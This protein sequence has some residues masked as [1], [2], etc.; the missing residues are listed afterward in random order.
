M[1]KH[2]FYLRSTI[3]TFLFIVIITG[4]VFATCRSTTFNPINDI[5]WECIYPV[6]IGGMEVIGTDLDSPPDTVG[7]QVCACGEGATAIVGVSSSFWEPARII[8]TVKDP[9]CFN[10]IG[11]NLSQNDDG[12]LAGT[13][14]SDT[15]KEYT[16][17]Q[18]HYY[19]LNV[20]SFLDLFMDMPCLEYQGF[21]LAY[22]TE[23]DPLWNDDLLAFILN[24]E[25]ILFGNPV[26]Q[27]ACMADAA[28]STLGYPLDVL[29]WCMG[30][31]GS[32]YPLAGHKTDNFYVQDN[33]AIAA[34]LVYKLTRQ[35][36]LWDTASNVCGPIMF[37]IWQKSHFRMH[38]MKPVKD[39]TCHPI[40][41]SGM[42]WAEMKNP[43]LNTEGDAADNFDWVL[44]RKVLCCV[45]FS[46]T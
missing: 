44:F 22:L 1:I 35:L 27:L 5:C 2:C 13:L 46:A 34:K 9:Y 29:F 3:Y 18:A 4:N 36:M 45:G 11:A 14:A 8:E 26:M 41:R 30:S 16:A 15:G 7:S 31:W 42:I 6:S 40:G 32:S 43:T 20:W 37:P 25:A 17:T 39:W 23:I 33:A 38:V 10:L 12:F 24:P 21:D 28:A 19:L